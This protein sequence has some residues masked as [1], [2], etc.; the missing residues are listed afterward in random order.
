VACPVITETITT[1]QIEKTNMKKLLKTLLGTS[2]Y[3]LEQSDSAQKKRDR[4]A[5]RVHDCRDAVHQKYEDAVDRVER[6][7]ITI[8]GEDTRLHGNAL[9]LAAVIG[10]GIGVGLL[11]AHASSQDTRKSPGGKCSAIWQRNLKTG[12]VRPYPRCRYR[13]LAESKTTDFRF[14]IGVNRNAPTC[15]CVCVPPEGEKYCR[16]SCK[17]AGSGEDG[18]RVRLRSSC[19]H[20]VK[21]LDWGQLTRCAARLVGADSNL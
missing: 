17:D 7:S 4:A 1:P 12:F 20:K 9:R 10:V 11:F 8:R 2:L 16:Q 5:S 3:L 15:P 21:L 19:L 18:N 14:L 6:A 13:R